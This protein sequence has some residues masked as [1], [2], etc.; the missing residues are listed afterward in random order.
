VAKNKYAPES[1]F[2]IF[3]EMNVGK[4]FKDQNGDLW[5]V[6]DFNMPTNVLKVQAIYSELEKNS[7]SRRGMIKTLKE[8][9]D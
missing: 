4:K 8:V 2:Q 9:V 3:V 7:K 5:S 6:E 1:V